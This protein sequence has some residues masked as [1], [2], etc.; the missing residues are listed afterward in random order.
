MRTRPHTKFVNQL[1]ARRCA[2]CGTLLGTQ[3]KRC[4]RCATPGTRPK[5]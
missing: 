5:K 1:K 4:K 3:R 2:K